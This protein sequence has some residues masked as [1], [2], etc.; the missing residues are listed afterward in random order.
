MRSSYWDAERIA[1]LRKLW[2]EGVSASQIALRLGGDVT[3]NAVVGK[4]N[5]MGFLQRK[6]QP[7]YRVPR[8]I[9]MVRKARPTPRSWTLGSEPLP[10]TDPDERGRIA[11]ADLEPHHCRYIPGDDR[12]FCGADRAAGLPYCA[13]HA[14]RCYSP[15]PVRT[16]PVLQTRAREPVAVGND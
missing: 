1:T 16:A 15:P 7:I 12:L 6:P 4:A 8:P 9:K 10:P 3:R 14:R 2:G 13:A 5:R 11:V